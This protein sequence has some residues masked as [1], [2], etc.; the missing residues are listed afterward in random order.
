MN[1]AY[2]RLSRTV[3]TWKKSHAT[4]PSA[5]ADRN[6]RH[7]SPARRGADRSASGNRIPAVTL[8]TFPLLVM[9]ALALTGVLLATV[10]AL[11]PAW[12]AARGATVEPLR[13]E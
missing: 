13:A 10:G 12:W 6:C 7:V 8:E 3:S 1:K 11:P 5:C 4:I 2:R 9:P